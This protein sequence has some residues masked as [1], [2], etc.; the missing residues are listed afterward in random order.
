MEP[1][2]AAKVDGVNEFQALRY[3]TLPLLKPVI[4]TTVIIKSLDTFRNFTYMWIMTRGGPANGTHTLS[5]YIYSN[6]FTL[7]K[8]GKGATMG[9]ITIVLGFIIVLVLYKLFDKKNEMQ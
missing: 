7:F 5:T 8:Y 9:V 2:E 1:Y 3:L 6:A 4:S